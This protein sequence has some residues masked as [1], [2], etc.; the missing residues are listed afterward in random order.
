MY[1]RSADSIT[2]SGWIY[3]YIC[4]KFSSFVQHNTFQAILVHDGLRSF[5]LYAYDENSIQWSVPT[6]RDTRAEF[7]NAVVGFTAPNHH[8]SDP[9]SIESS[10]ASIDDYPDIKN[11]DLLP[12]PCT[13]GAM[14]IFKLYDAMDITGPEVECKQWNLAEPDPM[15]WTRYLPPCPCYLTQAQSDGTFREVFHRSRTTIGFRC[16]Q[17]VFPTQLGS[18]KYLCKFKTF[19]R[20]T[21]LT[22]QAS[23]KRAQKWLFFTLRA[24]QREN[25]KCNPVGYGVLGIDRRVFHCAIDEHDVMAIS[26]HVQ[27][28]MI[29]MQSIPRWD[30]LTIKVAHLLQ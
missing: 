26:Q 14:Y 10:I 7:G 22:L 17:S 30:P 2:F 11:K 12:Q 21:K 28:R 4:I 19:L 5:A 15:T 18:G 24:F 1:C 16:F 9:R 25:F 27:Q 3:F 8:Y 6:T 23:Q 29:V 13:Y 20:Y